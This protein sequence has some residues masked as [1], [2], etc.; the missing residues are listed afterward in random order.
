MGPL[1]GGRTK[2]WL[3]E[4]EVVW[5]GRMRIRPKAGET[6]W[7][8]KKTHGKPRGGKWSTGYLGVLGGCLRRAGGC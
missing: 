1:S 7:E 2:W 3:H 4:G 6:Q 8:W 5:P